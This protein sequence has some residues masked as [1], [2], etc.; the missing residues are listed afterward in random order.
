VG[1]L[2]RRE[3]EVPAPDEGPQ[4][5]EEPCPRPEVAAAGPGLD[6]GRALPARLYGFDLD[7]LAPIAATVGPTLDD[8]ARPLDSSDIP[9]EAL[10][11]PAFALAAAG[12]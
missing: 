5:V 10:R 11:C 7:A 12:R 2:D 9:A 8:V 1:V 6:V 3:V 4:R